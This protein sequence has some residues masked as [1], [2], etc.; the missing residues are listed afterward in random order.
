M[1]FHAVIPQRGTDV[2]HFEAGVTRKA[3]HYFL[4]TDAECC[5]GKVIGCLQRNIVSRHEGVTNRPHPCNSPRMQRV[6][7][8]DQANEMSRINEDHDC[9][10]WP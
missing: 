7:S 5:P 2:N 6:A 8:I 3:I 10:G 4:T 1:Q 9:L